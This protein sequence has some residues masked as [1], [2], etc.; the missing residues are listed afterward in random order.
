VTSPAPIPAQPDLEA[1]VWAQLK[2][3]AGVNSWSYQA[4][5][6]WPGWIYRHFVQVDCR[7]KRKQAA[8]DLAEQ[9]RQIMMG[10]PDVPWAQGGVVYVQPVEGPFWLPDPD[11]LPRYVARYE[12]RVH[13]PRPAAGALQA[14][15]AA[16]HPR[17][18]RHPTGRSPAS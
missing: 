8:H 12:I 17:P 16:H 5:Q 9:A 11:G 1:W 7:A 4:T 13:P 3:L 18:Q 6:D 14:A 10:L 15:P 2:G